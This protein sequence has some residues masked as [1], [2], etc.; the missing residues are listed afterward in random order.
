[1]SGLLSQGFFPGGAAGIP[2]SL[3]LIT[4]LKTITKRENIAEFL[5]NKSVLEPP[6]LSN[7]ANKSLKY[8]TKMKFSP[9][10]TF[11]K[12]LGPAWNSPFVAPRFYY[13]L[14]DALKKSDDP[15]REYQEFG[16]NLY[17]SLND[18]KTD[19]FTTI[20]EAE[21]YNNHKAIFG[22]ELSNSLTAAAGAVSPHALKQIADRMPKMIVDENTGKVFLPSREDIKRFSNQLLLVQNPSLV[23]EKIQRGTILPSDVGFIKSVMPDF[24]EATV[25]KLQE[26]LAKNKNIKRNLATNINMFIKSSVVPGTNLDG[27]ENSLTTGVLQQSDAINQIEKPN[28]R[29]P[30]TDTPREIQ[31]RSQLQ[32]T[33]S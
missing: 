22:E 18:R 12:A 13:H 31:S 28:Y 14:G 8:R 29:L 16:Q 33:N 5:Y 6:A 24:Y 23:Y 1:M 17:D 26:Y 9:A 32:I 30:K 3:F 2:A 11:G 27:G 21:Q 7:K 4:G 25:K 15:V 20:Q 19:T 10:K